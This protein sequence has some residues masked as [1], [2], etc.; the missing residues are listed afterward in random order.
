MEIAAA[1]PSVGPPPRSRPSPFPKAPFFKGRPLF[2]SPTV[3]FP[4]FI[5]GV[6]LSVFQAND[7]GFARPC[8]VAVLFSSILLFFSEGQTR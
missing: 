7:A 4:M 8:G 2:V 3:G 1:D 5:D 6:R